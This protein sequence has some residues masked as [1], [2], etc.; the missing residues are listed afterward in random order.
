MPAERWARV[1]AIFF[2]A[3]D[4]GEADLATLL[5]ER[6]GG[7]TELAR[8]VESLLARH[9]Q[10]ESP[11]DRCLVEQDPEL[12]AELSSASL[13]SKL[14]SYRIVDELGRGGMGAVYAAVR[15]DHTYEQAVAI[16]VI[17]RGMDSEEI[18]RRFVA[19]R[20]ILARLDHP[21][22]ARLLDGGTTPDGR[23]YVVMERIVGR[24]LLAFCDQ[25][26]LGL[27]ERL[28]LFLKVAEAVHFAHQN[29]V[30]H[31]DL[32]PANVLVKE[33]GSPKLLDFGIAKLLEPSAPQL[34]RAGAEPLTPEYASPEQLSGGE[35]TTATDVFSL[36][37]LLYELLTGLHPR[38]APGGTGA[39]GEIRRA[40]QL[41]AR[42]G[43]ANAARRSRLLAGDLDLILEKSLAT[44]PRRRYASV[45]DFALDIE[46]HLEHQPVLAR[47]PTLGYR[48]RSFLLRY[49]LASAAGLAVALLAATTSWQA[50]EASRQRDRAERQTGRAL[51]LSEFMISLFRV[52]DPD[53]S[54]GRVVTARELLD[55]GAERLGSDPQAP[56]PPEGGLPELAAQPETRA[57]L[58][59][60]IG[61]VYQNL[62]LFT[63]AGRSLEG[64]AALQA[65]LAGR[66]AELDRARTEIQL[67]HLRRAEGKLE[68]SEALYRRAFT[69]RSRLLP[70]RD[71]G[72]VEAAN[73]LGLL[74][75][76]RGEGELARR[77]L[78]RAI[79]LARANGEAGRLPLAEALSNLAGV[80]ITLGEAERASSL[81]EE[82][83]QIHRQLLGDDHP[84][85]AGDLSNLGGLLYTRG[86]Y[87]GA[88]AHLRE[89]VA[90]RRRFLGPHHPHLAVALANLAAVLFEQG[91][92]AEAETCSREAL[93]I[94]RQARPEPHADV[95]HALNNL[96]SLLRQQGRPDEARPLLEEALRIY[97]GV[98][99]ERHAMVATALANLAL[100]HRD[101]GDRAAAERLAGEALKMRRE[102]LPP[103]HPAI[104]DSLLSL[105]G[106]LLDRGQARTARPLVD[107][108]HTLLL[109]RRGANHPETRRA[110][111]LLVRLE[112]VLAS[113]RR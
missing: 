12:A 74:H 16:K 64:A 110:A 68:E 55:R 61:E 108:A 80:E 52:S 63:E 104:A 17:K 105:G 13:G 67:A 78:L 22:I 45:R 50:W 28:R 41:L 42:S 75:A 25:R 94:Q 98:V 101:L 69:T 4:R 34:T 43:G 79:T 65:G 57:D 44:D 95:A 113:E 48:L 70:E 47:R 3:L 46:R 49:R 31:R 84:R 54:R 92:L 23:P 26:K 109:A 40:S 20:Q 62:G 83:R 89:A 36:G 112:A 91:T 6:S 5:A 19:E 99:G 15:D 107:E 53:Q 106:L 71:L 77:E 18:V 58:L 96:A 76:A 90:L 82:A 87:A 11:I 9:R 59:H 24:P 93:A 7:D 27:G 29:L 60:A 33:D 14:G 51:A 10:R 66:Q 21:A 81:L 111:E 56:L 97:R 85:T 100:T 72:L 2:E 103:D 73:G 35:I 39:G 38:A 88:A 30:V 86:D 8:E 1:K 102:V 32:K 37:L